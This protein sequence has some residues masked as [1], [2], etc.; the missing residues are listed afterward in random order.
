MQAIGILGGTFDPI[1]K[2]HLQ[3]AFDAK[4]QFPLSHVLFIPLNIPAHRSAPLASSLHRKQMIELAI[5]D[6][7]EFKLDTT[8]LDSKATSY[9]VNTLRK[10]R[11][12]YITSPL[13]LIMGRD[14]F[15]TIDKWYEWNKL[16]D[17]SHILVATRH[18]ENHHNCSNDVQSWTEQHTSN[19]LNDINNKTA[20]NIFFFDIPAIDISSSMI[21]QKLSQAQDISPLVD[22]TTLTYIKQHHLYQDNSCITKR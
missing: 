9:T 3:L 17:Y 20:G 5:H 12:T 11:Q 19:N 1:H 21:R 22:K 8:E 4:T 2:G 15:N 10:L 18:G 14:A 13:C 6:N 16:L 7:H